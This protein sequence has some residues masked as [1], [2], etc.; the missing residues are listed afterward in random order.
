[1]KIAVVIPYYPDEN[2]AELYTRCLDSIDSRFEVYNVIDF[3]HEGV[4]ATRN[5][6]LVEALKT[7]DYITF[8]D[9][10]DELAPDAYDSMK[11]A[12]RENPQADMI[13]F[14]HKRK[15]TNGVLQPRFWNRGGTYKL[16]KLPLLWVSSVNKIYK[17]DLLRVIRFDNSLRHGEDELFILECLAKTRRLICSDY[18]TMIYHK[19]NPK[20]LSQTT[21][22]DDLLGEQRALL[23]FI[24]GHRDDAE[25]CEA[26][27]IRQAELWNNPTYRRIMGGAE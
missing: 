21:A 5:R 8:L 9:A 10:D 3:K 27:R 15:L 23:R 22:F 1:M 14:N 19:D 20:S 13:Q 6:G 18:F 17:A 16:S 26:V 7:A 2:T 11:A 24:D 25:L 12:I 4:S